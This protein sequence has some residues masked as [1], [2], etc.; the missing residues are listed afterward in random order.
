MTLPVRFPVVSTENRDRR[1]FASDNEAGGHPAVLA[2]LV[3][4]NR[5]H[6]R[7]YGGDDHTARLGEVLKGH[8]G[9]A[10]ASFPVLTGTGANVL[11]VQAMSPPYGA[12]ICAGSA[13]LATSEGT[14]PES[15]AGLHVIGVP[16]PD[17]RL[18][19]DLVRRHA[20]G[21]GHINAAQPSV[22]SV[23]QVTECGTT[24]TPEQ[25]KAL[26]DCAHELGLVLHVDGARLANAAAY[27]GVDLRTLI[28]EPGVDI[29]SLGG[30]KNG[31]LFGEAVVVPRGDDHPA[32][33]KALPYL[34]KRATQL[35]SKMRFVSA[36][37][38]ALYEGDL[39]LRLASHAN[40]MAA[41][42]ADGLTGL[43]GVRIGYPVESNAVFVALAEPVAARVRQAF[44][45]H[46]W[47]DD[48][49]RWMC[50]FDTTPDDVDG[51]IDAVKVATKQE[52][53]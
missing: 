35:L 7:A 10:A 12:V 47:E 25:L 17:G 32:A 28:T 37:L 27:L 53:G 45:F 2:A 29:V 46:D 15:V 34:Q 50:S 39:W 23:S 8:F 13:H 41:R 31:L 22:V 4:A 48:V 36:Q 42:L 3:D 24:Y 9:P 21:I 18:T 14:A 6:Q 1:G 51:M 11:A 26:A 20:T 19:P 30:T 33:V 5:G 49:R 40:A 52:V 43:D 44:A 38:V 16:T